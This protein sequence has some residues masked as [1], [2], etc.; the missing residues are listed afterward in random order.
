[1]KKLQLRLKLAG[2]RMEKTLARLLA[3]VVGGEDTG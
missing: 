2:A 1:M 3:F